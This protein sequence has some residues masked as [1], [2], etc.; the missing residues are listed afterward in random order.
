MCVYSA[1]I[2]V[3]ERFPCDIVRQQQDRQQ[4]HSDN[5]TLNRPA[6]QHELFN[7]CRFG[8]CKRDKP[9]LRQN[10]DRKKSEQRA[11]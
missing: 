5:T 9:L 1:F 8:L 2:R 3:T 10:F 4:S 6:P 7:D 11:Q